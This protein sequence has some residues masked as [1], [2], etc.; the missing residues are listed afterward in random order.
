MRL[1][2][3][4]KNVHANNES[5]KRFVRENFNQIFNKLNMELIKNHTTKRLFEMK[6]MQARETLSK[7]FLSI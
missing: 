1:H 2:F 6:N 7:P 3:S 5:I 4:S